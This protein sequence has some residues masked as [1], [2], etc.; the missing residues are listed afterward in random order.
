MFFDASLIVGVGFLHRI[1]N[2]FLKQLT[3][4]QRVESYCENRKI[5]AS[6]FV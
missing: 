6:N 2:P 3:H 1:E 5:V 4:F